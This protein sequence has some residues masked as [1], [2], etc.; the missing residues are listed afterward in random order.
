[1]QDM[2]DGGEKGEGAHRRC[3]GVGGSGGGGEPPARDGPVVA[4]AAVA[5]VAA[6][7]ALVT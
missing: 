1:M 2:H 3:D 7:S 5:V 6:V 4:A